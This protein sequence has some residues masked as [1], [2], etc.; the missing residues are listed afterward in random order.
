MGKKV[1]EQE[2]VEK[3]V[4]LMD[5]LVLFARTKIKKSWQKQQ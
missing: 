5:Y 3:K 2:V 4:H 1:K